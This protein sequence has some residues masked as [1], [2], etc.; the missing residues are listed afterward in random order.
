MGLPLEI[1]AEDKM[2]LNVNGG[3]IFYKKS[4]EG[5]PL[6]LLHGLGFD[7]SIFDELSEKLSKHFTVYAPDTRNHGQSLKTEDYSYEIM[8]DDVYALIQSLNLGKV[9]LLGFSDGA[10][11]ALHVV[12]RH[13]EVIEKVAFL[14]L[15][16]K[17]T[18]L[19]EACMAFYQKCYKESH[20]PVYKL[21]ID[22]PQIELEELR[23]ITIPTLL[24]AAE[25]EIFRE[26]LFEELLSGFPNVQG[27][28]MKG[29]K[30]ETYLVHQDLLYPDLLAF[31]GGEAAAD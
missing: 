21:V 28:V 26:G 2:I 4:G 15:N 8:A 24:M 13:L 1:H 10:V 27:K 11:I 6:I 16:L 7:H 20:D 14:G 3:E 30:H 12:L 22:S 5:A 18:D 29:H 9:Y 17:P 31:F 19:N 25:R 23:A